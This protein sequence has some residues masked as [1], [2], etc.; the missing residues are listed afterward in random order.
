MIHQKLISTFSI[1]NHLLVPPRAHV[2]RTRLLEVADIKLRPRDLEG[3]GS[4][5]ELSSSPAGMEA[6]QITTLFYR[7]KAELQFIQVAL[8]NHGV[9][10]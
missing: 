9:R 4:H 5:L 3:Q 1:R 7:G 8:P 10:I 2:W 6:G